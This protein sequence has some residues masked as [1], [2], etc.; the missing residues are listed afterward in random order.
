M[1]E[2]RVPDWYIESCNKISYMFPK[3]HAVTYVTMAF[4]IAYFKVHYPLA[5]Y[6]TSFPSERETSMQMVAGAN[7]GCAEMA[8]IEAKGNDATAK[9]RSV[10]TCLEMVVEAM[11]RGVTLSESICTDRQTGI[12][13]LRA[14]ASGRPCLLQGVGVNAAAGIVAAREG[15]EFKSIEDLRQR[16]GITKAVIE[17]LRLHGCLEGLPET[18][19][20]TLF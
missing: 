16:A 4:R 12:F 6:A 3:A 10:L 15:G 2:H 7:A 17:T 14:A 19:Q 13:A 20:L 8:A 5:Y 1:K 9:E 18:N 11:S